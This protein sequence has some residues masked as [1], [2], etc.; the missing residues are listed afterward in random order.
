[1]IGCQA[2]KIRLKSV[3]KP[4]KVRLKEV[5]ELLVDT[6]KKLVKSVTV[7]LQC[8]KNTVNALSM[9]RIE[10]VPQ[11]PQKR[12]KSVADVSGKEDMEAA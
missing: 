11:P 4:C 6:S 10:S 8:P 5:Q 9:E 2:V 12:V 3:L 1:M 7:R